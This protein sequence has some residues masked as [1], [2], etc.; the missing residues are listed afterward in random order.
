MIGLMKSIDIDSLSLLLSFESENN[1][2]A[3]EVT[4]TPPMMFVG[5]YVV[6][7]VNIIILEMGV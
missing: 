3:A 7:L 4:V 6:S 1:A 2:S 5:N